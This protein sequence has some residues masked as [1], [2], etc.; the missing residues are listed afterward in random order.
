MMKRYMMGISLFGI[1]PI[2]YATIYYLPDV[3][4]YIT[5]GET[6]EI[7]LWQVGLICEH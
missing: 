2:L 5:T 4:T 1:L 6:E 7:E 3:W